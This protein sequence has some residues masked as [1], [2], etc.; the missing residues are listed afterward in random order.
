MLIEQFFD[1]GLGH[2]SYLVAD[3]DAGVAFLVDPDREIG[4]YLSAAARLG[5][6]ITDSLETHVH[7]DYVSG[8]RALAE[9]RPITVHA[10]A[11]AALVYPHASHADGDVIDVGDLRVRC[12]TTP[13]HTPEHV[14]YLVADL[15]R[16][17]DPQYLFSGGA[18]L[19]GQ[20]ARVDLLGPKLEEELARS[21]YDTLRDRVLTL[22]DYVAVFP[23]HGGGSA[24]SAEVA[25]SRWTTLGFERRHNHV[26]RSATGGFA[27]FRATIAEGLPVAPAYY[28]HVRTLNARGAPIASRAPLPFLRE[29]PKGAIRIDPRPPHLFGAGHQPG[30]LNVVGNDS[31][32][33]RIGA[34]VAFGAPI[35]IL[36]TDAEQAD[37]LRVQLGLIGYDDVRGYAS[38]DSAPGEET[39]RIEQLDPRA[40]AARASEKSALLLDVRERSEW[41]AGHAPGAVHIPYAALRERTPELPLDRP[42]VAYCAS[43]VRS[44]L[45]ASILE[46]SG[47]DVSNLRGGFTAWRNANLEVS[48]ET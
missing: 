10:G 40:A 39:R 6:L 30:A 31:F 22:A 3:L 45:A 47:H 46:A 18:L 28:P 41:D 2:A 11:D 34:T 5:V 27:A 8:S 12:V 13:G 9:L 19:V 25:G 44:S 33:V 35:V 24:C 16:S 36:T 29:I 21:A 1:A 20:I 48:T 42:I 7:N 14:A 17:D 38:P 23:T 4:T 15:R 43:G 26:A 32:A 37:R